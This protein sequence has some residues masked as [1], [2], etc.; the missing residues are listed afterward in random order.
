MSRRSA[1]AR[2]IGLVCAL[3]A[4]AVAVGAGVVA[5]SNVA[6][7]LYTGSGGTSVPTWLYLATGGGVIGASALLTMLVTDRGIIDSFH[8]DAVAVSLDQL[9]AAGSLV[10]GTLGVATL[11]FV[12]VVGF[13]GPQIGNFSAAVLVTFVGGRALLTILSYAVGSPWPALNPWRRIASV[14]PNGYATYPERLGTW[15][16]VAALLTLIWL[17]LVAPLSSSPRALAAVVVAYSAF[18]IAGGV[19]FTPETWFRRGDPLSVWFRFYGAV[20][21][22]QRTEDGLELRYP[23]ARLGDDDVVTDVS[24]VAFVLVLVW[25]LT[26]SGFVATTP[27]VRTVEAL[28]AIGLPPQLVYLGLLLAGFALFWKVYWIAA[29]RTRERAE[30]YLS[31]RY[32]AIRFAPPLLAIAAGYHF[33]HYAGFSISLWPSLIDTLAAPLNPPENPIQYAL[34]SWFGY[35]EIAGIL[36]GHVL[37]V[38]I[39]HAVSFELFPGKLQAIRSQYPFVVVM[40]FFTVVSLYLVSLPAVEAVYVPG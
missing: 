19:A 33:A 6:A 30:T 24:A 11:A 8:D 26:Y 18:T 25:E 31:R 22:I 23:G 2:R 38:W 37:A 40:I 32:L 17:E 10:L 4:V 15:P 12:V 36:L 9:R 14:L 34:T 21:P 7:G 39:S 20:A 1:V 29:E 35:V 27:G 3:T 28:V 5:A 13:V 16:A